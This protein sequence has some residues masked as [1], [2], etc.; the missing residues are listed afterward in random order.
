M[1]M[2]GWMKFVE[3]APERYDW[4][5]KLMTA[6]K[7]DRLKD[8]IAETIEPNDRVLDIGCGTGTLALRCLCRGAF[9]TGL[10][11]SEHMLSVARKKA[12]QEGVGARLTL[13][14]DSITQLHK[15]ATP[16]SFDCIVCTMVLGEFSVD[17][18]KYVFRECFEILRPGGRLLIADEVWPENLIARFAYQIMLAIAWIPQFLLL[19]R[20]NYPV[21]DLK[22]RIAESGFKITHS[23]SL[24]LTSFNLISAEKP[25]LAPR[26]SHSFP[27]SEPIQLAP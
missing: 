22:R 25:A 9:V 17:Y 16:M 12:D 27:C 23:E 19:R 20:V 21:L 4:A 3:V 24:L 6:G 7:L 5:V 11:I 18:L 26:V 13:I 8:R 14:K 15:H 1:L 2:Y 10:D